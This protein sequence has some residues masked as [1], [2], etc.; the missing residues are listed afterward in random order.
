M[1]DCHSLFGA[2]AVDELRL[3]YRN[4][5]AISDYRKII[6]LKQSA[7]LSCPAALLPPL[8]LACE[9]RPTTESNLKPELQQDL[10][11]TFG[12]FIQKVRRTTC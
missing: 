7:L 5:S 9:N 3:P 6:A 8:I 2:R 10:V 12:G 11:I 1:P 4:Y